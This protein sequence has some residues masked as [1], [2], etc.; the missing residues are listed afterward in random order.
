MSRGVGERVRGSPIVG[1]LPGVPERSRVVFGPEF[2]N[3][4]KIIT[5]VFTPD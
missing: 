5:V 3:N 1:H 4:M 2:A